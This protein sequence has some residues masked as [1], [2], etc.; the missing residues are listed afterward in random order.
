[1][2]HFDIVIQAEIRFLLQLYADITPLGRAS[3]CVFGYQVSMEG[4][5]YKGRYTEMLDSGQKFGCFVIKIVK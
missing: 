2:D 4:Q 3:S 5:E 1:M